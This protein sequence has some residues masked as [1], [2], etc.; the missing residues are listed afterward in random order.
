MDRV[1]I[2]EFGRYLIE[3]SNDFDR[4]AL[5]NC[6]IH[7]QNKNEQ[8]GGFGASYDILSARII[9]IVSNPYCN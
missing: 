1:Q 9:K 3:L 8:S 7:E 5:D 4:S 6:Y 2:P